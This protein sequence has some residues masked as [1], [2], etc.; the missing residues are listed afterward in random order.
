MGKKLTKSNNKKIFGVCGGIADYFGID[1]TL[2]RLGVVILTII[3]GTGIL[4]YILAALVMP[5]PNSDEVEY[6]IRDDVPESQSSNS[7]DYNNSESKNAPHSDED[8]EK[9]FKK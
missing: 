2:V 8:F 9:F 3:W 7:G 4:I 1:A 5:E 6:V